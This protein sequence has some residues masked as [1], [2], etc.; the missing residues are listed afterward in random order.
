MNFP[1]AFPHSHRA[2][3]LAPGVRPNSVG[4]IFFPNHPLKIDL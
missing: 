1:L 4:G 3:H 2:S